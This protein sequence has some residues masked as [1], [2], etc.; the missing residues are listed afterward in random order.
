MAPAI[1]N[2]ITQ[3][4]RRKGTEIVIEQGNTKTKLGVI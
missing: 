1:E 2:T 3:D 4:Q